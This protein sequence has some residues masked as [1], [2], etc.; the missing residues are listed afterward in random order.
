MKLN[1]TPAVLAG[2]LS[3]ALLSQ[4]PVHGQTINTVA[5]GGSSTNVQASRFGFSFPIFAAQYAPTGD[6]Y[7]NV[8]GEGAIRKISSSG[9]VSLVAGGTGTNE[10]ADGPV[11]GTGLFPNLT[12]LVIDTAGNLYITEFSS[13]KMRKIST[14]GTI[15]TICGN[16]TPGF[17]GDNGLA[18]S[19]KL[20]YPFGMAIDRTG[21]IYVAD[22]FNHRV[23]KISTSGIITTVAGTGTA[24]YSGDGA[25]ATGAMLN[26]PEG[27]AVDT[28]GNL[29]IAD[30]VN[31][32]IRKVTTG[33]I[34]STYAGTGVYGSTGDGGLAT[35]A[36]LSSPNAVSV[37]AS[38]NLYITDGNAK[39]R[40]VT[41]AGTITTVAGTGTQGF[42]GDNGPAVSAQLQGAWGTMTDASGNLLICDE[43]NQR[44]RKVTPGG[45][46]STF[47]GNGSNYIGNNG[48]A[49]NAVLYS[50]A[51]VYTDHAGNI[52]F[53]DN[54]TVLKVDLSGNIS[55]FAGTGP[56]YSATDGYPANAQPVWSPFGVWGDPA[57]NIYIGCS[58]DYTVRK[59]DT[60]GIMT[61]FAGIAGTNGW[62]GDN[63]PA[64]SAA[65]SKSQGIVG[66]P[67]GNIYIT[68]FYHGVI[69]KVTPAGIIS[70]F[71]GTGTPGYSGDN[72][73]AT[74]AQLGAPNSICVDAA[75]NIYVADDYVNSVRK[76]T[77]GGF[78]T[79]VAGG[80]ASTGNTG[81]GGP[82]TAALFGDIEGLTCDALGNLYIVDGQNNRVRR[83]D[84]NTGIISPFAGTGTLGFAG[85]NG[86]ALNAEFHG[87]WAASMDGNGNVYIGDASNQR[88]R[89]ITIPYT[90][91]TTSTTV[92]QTINGTLF[93]DVNDDLFHRIVTITPT[94]GANALSGSVLFGLT[95]DPSIQLYNGHPYVTRHY[96]ITPSANPST[97]QATVKLY[98]LQ[99][100]FDAYNTYVSTNGLGLPVLP[101][102]AA[103]VTDMSNISILQFH[104]TGTAPGNYTGSA[105]MITPSVAFN[106][107]NNWWEI[108]FPVDGFSGFFLTSGTIP[109]PLHLLSFTGSLQGSN[110]TLKWTT[111]DEKATRLFSVERSGN[112]RDFAPIGEV[113]A[114]NIAG[115][116]WYQYTDQYVKGGTWYYRLR[117]QD[118]DGKSTY[119]NII[120]LNV[121]IDFQGMLLYP[122]P[123]NDRLYV[124]LESTQSEKT[125]VRLLDMQGKTLIR[126]DVTLSNGVTS[127]TFDTRGLAKGTYFI[128]VAGSKPQI[129]Q[130]IKP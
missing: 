68:D 72:G 115:T 46:I 86:P 30:V 42:S 126:Q 29:Y 113:A 51:A 109:L 94:S 59:V 70:T 28:S 10:I 38:G 62:S 84:V 36:Q 88:I 128:S 11:T 104:G 16:G 33:G 58:G 74:S 87:P 121:G 9:V 34:I 82:A 65:I 26:Q 37:D 60:S 25:A 103:D 110:I 43:S 105:K 119:S 83:V 96:D 107:D 73:P 6:I 8:N 23:R 39:V 81:D 99:S 111:T 80:T 48:L 27:V 40:K 44:I 79:T 52:Y 3:I 41:L 31:N 76:I 124:Q 35:S 78:I 114:Q 122:N 20:N 49:T 14:S 77:P 54:N 127:F 53:P 55:V 50:P 66:D 102:N 7:V 123:V 12:G 97:S 63:G 67:S 120:S 117:M 5:G 64:T 57:G 21:N 90:L 47:A 98:F 91:P 56:G 69:R 95:F 130:F 24:G 118:I 19:A 85:D 101:V 45:A 93:T 75:G 116:H 2:S 1:F 22:M 92:T 108:S 4:L 100:E 129:R 13:C 89:K 18:T 125:E 17:S 32:R 106:S 61:K 15:T 112:A 71:A